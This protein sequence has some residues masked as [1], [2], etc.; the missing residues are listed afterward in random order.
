MGKLAK[1]MNKKIVLD[2]KQ[3][4]KGNSDYLTNPGMGLELLAKLVSNKSSH[5]KVD[6]LLYEIYEMIH[7][8]FMELSD[9]ESSIQSA[10]A[11]KGLMDAYQELTDICY[12]PSFENKNILAIGGHFSAGKSRFLNAI[13]NNKRL[14]PVD[15]TPTTSIPTYILK[16][17]SDSVHILNKFQNKLEISKDALKVIAHDFNRTYN[18]SFSH[19]LKL[20]TIES[21]HF[22]HENV[23][24][25]DTPGYSK[26]DEI[27]NKY[28]NT[29]ENIAREH[30]RIADRL[31]WL[32]D[33]NDGT[34][35]NGDIQFIKSLAHEMPILFVLNKADMVPEKQR[36]EVVD[37]AKA[38][39]VKAEIDFEAVIPYSSSEGCEY[40]TSK[41]GIQ[42]FISSVNT[43]KAGTNIIFKFISVI[44]EFLAHHESQKIWEDSNNT[45]LK[46]MEMDG[47]LQATLKDTPRVGLNS[48]GKR[49]RKNRDNLSRLKNAILIYQKRLE[50]K[51]KEVLDV[52]GISIIE[53]TYT[54][55]KSTKK[56]SSKPVK[57]PEFFAAIDSKVKTIET[58]TIDTRNIMGK[59]MKVASSGV[60]I[61]LEGG[62]S[63][64]ISTEQIK[65][66]GWAMP[67]LVFKEDMAVTVRLT[68][69]NS[70]FV[71]LQ[72]K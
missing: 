45:L 2:T 69:K 66:H 24:F 35:P 55:N 60:S 54:L 29:D 57:Y 38:T 13:T 42:T 53:H 11:Y 46:T 1:S 50:E 25:I 47:A 33:I 49:V 71:K 51:I 30:L 52:Q 14:L 43:T 56:T 48:M 64:H 37:A 65:K 59:V 41:N 6:T 31:I 32:T 44:K 5:R 28:S 23:M 63:A 18:L 62:I 12:F 27:N 22:Q 10:Q 68:S 3:V 34:I 4:N 36:Q 40:S 61:K 8:E 72:L 67:G 58:I 39:L 17:K 70:G 7:L 20:I 9:N 19:L 26:V 21:E 15:Q 16:G